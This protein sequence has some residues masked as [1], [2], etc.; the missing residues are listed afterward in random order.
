MSDTQKKPP[1]GLTPQYIWKQKRF[2]EIIL[3]C[4]RYIEQ[5]IPLNPSWI[6]ELKG[7]I[8]DFEE[9]KE[10]VFDPKHQPSLLNP[11]YI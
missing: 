4:A 7:L 11:R 2:N 5:E 6:I 10:V 8:N 1:L 3:V 9:T